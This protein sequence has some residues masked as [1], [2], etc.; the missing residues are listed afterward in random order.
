M[1]EC[2]P[3]EGASFNVPRPLRKRHIPDDPAGVPAPFPQPGLPCCDRMSR[4]GPGTMD[5]N[6][7]ETT[8][9]IIDF[10]R[11]EETHAATIYADG[12]AI[13]DDGTILHLQKTTADSVKSRPFDCD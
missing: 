8:T 5:D 4:N 3:R 11:G 1:G 12:L 10:G 6:I 13:L 7:I 2:Y 9:I